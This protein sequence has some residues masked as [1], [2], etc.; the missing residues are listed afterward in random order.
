MTE[1]TK[2]N[3]TFPVLAR[4][5]SVS[6]SNLGT[7]TKLFDTKFLCN[8]QGV[9]ELYECVLEKLGQLRPVSGGFQFLISFDDRTHF[10]HHNINEL[11]NVVKNSG[12]TTEQLTLKWIAVHKI[13]DEDNEL[14]V[15]VRISNPVNPLLVLQA[16]LSKSLHEFDKLEFK[17]GSISVSVDGAGQIMAEEIFSIIGRWVD[18]RPQPQYITSIHET[19]FKHQEKIAFLNYWV[20]PVL[21]AIIFFF[22]LWKHTP[23]PLLIPV[24][25][26]G[27]VS[28]FYLRTIG[29]K[30]N[31]KIKR[32]CHFSFLFSLFSLTGGDSNQQAKFASKSQN[33]L[34]R[35]VSVTIGTFI[36]N[37]AA[38]VVVS[39]MY[40]L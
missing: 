31:D 35:L 24:L 12:K 32:W 27:V 15:V 28:N 11:D 38:G 29:T 33:S 19:I 20:L 34:I 1:L 2:D 37:V 25:F 22:A 18:S 23:E 8:L 21:V 17:S 26:A 7:V 9:H 16:A 36:L 10:E 30:L 6:K 5:F 4:P 3:E 14:T 13:D 39:W 40:G